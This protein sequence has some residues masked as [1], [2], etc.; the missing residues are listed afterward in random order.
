MSEKMREEKNKREIHTHIHTQEAVCRCLFKETLLSQRPLGLFAQVF[1]PP[2][3]RIFLPLLKSHPS[4][5]SNAVSSDIL[6]R[7]AS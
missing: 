1:S 6:S 7:I 4:F 5:S 2:G 3:G